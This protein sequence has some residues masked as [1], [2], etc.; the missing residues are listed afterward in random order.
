MENCFALG[1]IPQVFFEA[2]FRISVLITL[3]TFSFFKEVLSLLSVKKAPI[4]DSESQYKMI[5]SI[6]L[7]FNA[8]Q[9]CCD[10]LWMK[11]KILNIEHGKI[12]QTIQRDFQVPWS[13]LH[14]D[15]PGQI[16]L[17]GP[18]RDELLTGMHSKIKMAKGVPC[19]HYLTLGFR[20]W[21]RRFLN[22]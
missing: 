5:I 11:N 7:S 21:N 14:K 18:L 12:H 8:A 6:S 9:Q 20:I 2:D 22:L 16:V 4:S 15:N 17:C 19:C 1:S 3:V 13:S 10:S